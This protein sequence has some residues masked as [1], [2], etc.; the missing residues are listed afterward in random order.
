MTDSI[1]VTLTPDKII[2]QP[3]GTPVESV[4]TIQNAGATV[5]QYAVEL[6]QLP[7]TWYSLA[8]TSVALFPQDKE[9]AKLV[10]HPPKGG[11]TKAGTYPFTVTVLSRADPS[12]TTRVEGTLQI[13]SVASFDVSM[14]P[15][16]VVGRKGHYTI[17]M[18]NGGNAD[19]EVELEGADSEGDCRYSFEPKQV[20]LEAGAKSTTRLDVQ[21]RRFWLVGPRKQFDIQVRATP[22]TGA[23][24]TVN[25]QFTHTPMFRTWRPI[26]RVIFLL[27]LLAVIAGA[28]AEVGGVNGLHNRAQDLNTATCSHLSLFCSGSSA[29]MSAKPQPTPVGQQQH[30][31][32]TFVDQFRAFHLAAPKLV[33]Q[34]LENESTMAQIATQLTTNGLLL[35]DHKSGHAFLVGHDATVWEFHKNQLQQVR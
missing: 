21:A 29:P 1:R 9:D 26:R 17:T 20:S 23:M 25:A 19:L 2:V 10:L 18:R 15:S 16:K 6:D 12:L 8:N 14:S 27:V 33:G 32:A 3:D 30:G 7:T 4:I 11:N 24:K 13:G 34:P 28:L 35:F 22:R 31:T 5:D